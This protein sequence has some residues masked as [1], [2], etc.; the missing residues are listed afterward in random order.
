LRKVVV[1]VKERN[2][3]IYIGW[4]IFEKFP[5]LCLSHKIKPHVAIIT[6]TNVSSLYL[7]KLLNALTKN[8]YKPEPIIVRSGESSK[9]LS[10]AM[11]IYTQLIKINLRRDETIIAFGGGVIGDLAG[12]VS[13]TFLR[14]VNLI[15]FPT[16][17]LAQVDSSIGGK[18]AINHPLGKN[19]IGSFHHPVFVFSDISLLSSLPKREMICG[20]GEVVKYGII[21]DRKIFEIIENDVE[22][23]LK[24]NPDVLLEIVHRSAIV[25]SEIVEKDEKE[26]RLR[27]VLNFGH[28]IGHGIEAGLNYRK[29]KHGEAVMLGIIG[30]SFIS[31]RRGL[32][33]GKTFERIKNLICSLGVKFPKKLLDK[34]KILTHIG[35]DKK[36]FSDRLNMYL[37]LGLGKMKFVDDV[38]FTEIE[39]AIEFIYDL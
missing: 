19:L 27:M 1:N 23:I 13:A 21:K 17:L 7:D 38:K 4:E 33:D 5:K 24:P 22:K 12:F 31:L 16:T 25:K 32:I 29:L 35:Y 10:T 3:P 28:T 36:I 18:V 6:D 37:P 26:K 8:G 34:E 30:E 20:L 14:G 9:N 15:Q 2:Y 11:K 39:K